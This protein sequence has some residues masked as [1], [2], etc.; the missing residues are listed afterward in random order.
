MGKFFALC[1]I[2]GQIV[3]T[4]EKPG[5]GQFALAIGEF[6]EVVDTITKTSGGYAVAVVPGVL[7]DATDRD[8]LSAIARYIQV[9]DKHNSP[10][11]RALGA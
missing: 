1:N 5:E 8:N 2:K 4:D 9:L 11:F 6:D 3:V 10:G 7:D